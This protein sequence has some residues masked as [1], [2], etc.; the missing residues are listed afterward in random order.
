MS[1]VVGRWSAAWGS[2]P[3]VLVGHAV[4]LGVVEA[5]CSAPGYVLRL[6]SALPRKNGS[7]RWGSVCMRPKAAGSVTALATWPRY[8]LKN[9]CSL[10]SGASFRLGCKAIE[11][12]V[13]V[14]VAVAG[15]GEGVHH[16]L[17]GGHHAPR[18][19]LTGAAPSLASLGS[20]FSK[21]LRP[22]RS[23]SSLML[24][25]SM[26]SIAARAVLA[27][28]V[29]GRLTVAWSLKG[30]IIQNWT[31]SMLL[32]SKSVVVM[33]RVMPAQLF[34]GSLKEPLGLRRSPVVPNG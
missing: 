20:P 23:T 1:S 19:G 32:A 12:H 17:G 33:R 25:R 34:S 10:P 7:R 14:P 27:V 6:S 4:A 15:E 24:P 13:L 11:A 26:Y 28:L 2:P 16:A 5:A 18:G 9:C 22:S 8:S 21:A 3:A 31:V 30:S 29:A